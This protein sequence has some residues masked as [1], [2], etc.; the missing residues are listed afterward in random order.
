MKLDPFQGLIVGLSV[1]IV[2]SAFA[3]PMHSP[4]AR[5]P[6][7]ATS[8]SEILSFA[9]TRLLVGVAGLPVLLSFIGDGKLC[10]NFL[11]RNVFAAYLIIR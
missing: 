4:A 6:P 11:Q 5:E 9:A 3:A 10:L 8:P 2:V 7:A 1:L